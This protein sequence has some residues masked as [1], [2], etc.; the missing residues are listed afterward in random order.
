MHVLI[1]IIVLTY[2]SPAL[3]HI[4]LSRVGFLSVASLLTASIAEVDTASDVAPNA[5]AAPHK[6]HANVPHAVV[7]LLP[8]TLVPLLAAAHDTPSQQTPSLVDSGL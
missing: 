4:K 6:E 3:Y 8:L 2:E 5:H 7:V 1:V